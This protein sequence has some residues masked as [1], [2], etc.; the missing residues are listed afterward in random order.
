MS[1]SGKCAKSSA[2][3]FWAVLMMAM[4]LALTA[5]G[6]KAEATTTPT[7]APTEPAAE[8]TAEPTTEPTQAAVAE[9]YPLTVELPDGT[10]ITLEE[11]VQTIVSM[12]PNMTEIL[13]AIG[14]GDKLVGRTDYCDYPAEALEVQSIGS[15]YSPDI[16]K[17]IELNPDMVIGSTHFT[18][19]SAKRLSELGIQVVTLYDASSVDGVYDI[20][21]TI[22]KLTGCEAAA[23]VLALD[24]EAK[25][26]AIKT[27]VAA[28]E[29]QPTVYYVVGY[30]EYG[31]YT[32][33]GDTFI[34]QMITAAGGI[35]IAEEVS[36]WS[37]TLE[38]L[39]EA[40]PDVIVLGLGEAAAFKDA[41]NYCEL[42]AVKNDRVYEI[43]RNLLDRQGYRNAEGMAALAEIFKS[44]ME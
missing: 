27:E 31:D 23:E 20:I 39:I 43:D 2:K 3:R 42:S 36:G 34:G 24:T 38:A 5:C 6:S 21:R 28:T 32:A 14:A 15:I 26:E 33:G 10:S 11:E 29:N 7:A 25:I 30:G 13:Y 12:G 4:M 37:Y 41:T 8:P 9:E 1:R 19:E 18:E 35:N 22:G 44:A 40:D 16:E 17:I